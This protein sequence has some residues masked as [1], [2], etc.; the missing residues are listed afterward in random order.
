[1]FCARAQE[2]GRVWLLELL[3]TK[4]TPIVLHP[5]MTSDS[6]ALA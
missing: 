2:K 3:M 6:K 5:G 1:M 4:R